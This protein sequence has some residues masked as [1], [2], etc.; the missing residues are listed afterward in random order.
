M[1]VGRW[2]VI[3]AIRDS[4]TVGWGGDGDARVERRRGED[5]GF[6][7][8]A[9]TRIALKQNVN[10]TPFMSLDDGLR[11]ASYSLSTLNSH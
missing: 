9:A 3:R 8:F 7:C 4:D 1:A 5:R 6:L 2:V 10:R 11:L